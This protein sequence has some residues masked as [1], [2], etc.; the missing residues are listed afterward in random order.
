MKSLILTAVLAVYAQSSLAQNGQ[1]LVGAEH[2]LGKTITIK[3][4]G[5]LKSAKP[6]SRPTSSP[7]AERIGITRTGTMLLFLD[8]EGSDP[9]RSDYLGYTMTLNAKGTTGGIGAMRYQTDYTNGVL[10][11]ELSNVGMTDPAQT[12]SFAIAIPSDGRSCAVKAFR[13]TNQLKAPWASLNEETRLKG[14]GSCQIRS[15]VRAG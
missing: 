5:E 11:I 4:P 13:W 2:L 10:T 7:V 1:H 8:T 3:G 9:S 15:G 14:A 6:R 12:Y